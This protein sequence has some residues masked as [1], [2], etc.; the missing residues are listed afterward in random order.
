[1][2]ET[3]QNEKKTLVEEGTELR[4]TI[5]SK[6]PIVVH[7]SLDGEI[8]APSLTISA[9]GTVSGTVKVDVLESDGAISG[10]FDAGTVRLAG[11]IQNET[12][13]RAKS[14]EVKLAPDDGLLQVTFGNCKLEV[15]DAPVAKK[16]VDKPAEHAAPV[17]AADKPVEKRV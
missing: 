9:T 6:C 10:R 12:V 1:M 14:L 17:K 5:T 3:K 13:I 15:G 7:G 2:A 8:H 4:G 16:A 11:K